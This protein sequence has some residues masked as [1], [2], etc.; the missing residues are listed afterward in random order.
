MV[1]KRVGVLSAG[2]VLAVLQGGVGL[3]IGAI[4]SLVAVLGASLGNALAEE[5]GAAF[6]GLIFGVGAIVIF[7]ICYAIMGFV[8]GIIGA[9]IYNLVAGFT[10]GIELDLE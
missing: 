2:K 10:G 8:G 6:A 1:L 3:M 5:G 7:P 9:A 4:V